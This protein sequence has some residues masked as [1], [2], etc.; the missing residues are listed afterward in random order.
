M[1]EIAPSA[2][3]A[4]Q[5]WIISSV[6]AKIMPRSPQVTFMSYIAMMPPTFCLIPITCSMSSSRNSNSDEISFYGI[7]L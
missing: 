2:P 6:A 3:T 7:T 4:K 5:A 1:A